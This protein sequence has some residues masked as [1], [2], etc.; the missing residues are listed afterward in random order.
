MRRT[1]RRAVCLRGRGLFSGRPCAVRVL[2]A[3][4]GSGWQWRVARRWHRLSPA[5]AAPLPHRARLRAEGDELVLP[6][7]L[8]AALVIADLD[9]VAIEVPGGEVPILDGSGLPFAQALRHAGCRADSAALD[10]SVTFEGRTARWT[11]GWRPTQARTFID[12]GAARAQRALFRGADASTALVRD[13]AHRALG[14]RGHRLSHEPA[15][16]KL[17]DLLGDL[18]PWRALGPLRGRIHARNPSHD[19]TPDQIRRWLADGSLRHTL[20]LAA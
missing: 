18:G 6:E 9:D 20:S 2:P 4:A 15:W 12:L 11:G 13:G 17:L 10:V 19:R 1:L 3:A 5:H 8:L 16:H 7:H 14:A